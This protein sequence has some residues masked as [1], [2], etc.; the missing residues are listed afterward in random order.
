MGWVKEG[1]MDTRARMLFLTIGATVALWPGQARPQATAPPEG[2]GTLNGLAP[3]QLG[4]VAGASV[5]H[6]DT[7]ISPPEVNSGAARREAQVRGPAARALAPAPVGT[8]DPRLL[9]WE[10]ATGFENIGS[11]RTDV[12]RR[13]Q[14]P[15]GSVQADRL[16]LRWT[17]LETGRVAGA[18]AVGTTPIDADVLDCVKRQMT[19]WVFS[20]PSGGPVPVERTFAFRPVPPG[21]APAPSDGGG[22]TDRDPSIF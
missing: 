18:T 11:C 14:V 1:S 7:E 5:G 4:R 22:Q 20:S 10:I 19:G 6:G 13:R 3:D 21:S 2:P 17:I 9:A 16:T 8:L 12:A 15:V